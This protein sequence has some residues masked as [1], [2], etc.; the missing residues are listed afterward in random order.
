MVALTDIVPQRRIVTIN[1]GTEVELRG[2]GLR[3]ISSLLL[4]F[5]E[6]RNLWSNGAPALDFETIVIAAPDA[7][8]AIIAESAG[9]PD[10][11]DTIA[12]ALSLDDCAECLG[13][14]LGLTMPDGLAPFMERLEKLFG[15]ADVS[16]R[17]A[18]KVPA[19]TTQQPLSN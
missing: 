10:A 14:V 1:G 4:R 18:G 13:A 15:A 11:A 3:Q 5:P 12:D 6:L 19:T 9:Q 2:L 17:L 7:I 8:G 16:A